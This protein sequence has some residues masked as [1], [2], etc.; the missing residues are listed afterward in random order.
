[1]CCQA[2]VS[3]IEHKIGAL[4]GVE[5]IKVNQMLRRIAVSH[6]AD[7][8]TAER[9][10]RTLNWSLLGASLVQK[11]S[12]TGL[13]RGQLCTKEAWV[14]LTCFVLF[15]IAGG[16]WARPES[17]PW[18]DDPFTYAALS[19]ISVGA[20]VLV[21]RTFAGLRYQRSLLNM[22]ATMLIAVVGACILRDFWEAA[23]IVFV[24]TRPA[25]S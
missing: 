2:E 6:D 20:P 12:T 8:V 7:K 15:A 25:S 24:R 22:F 5:G 13:R 11:G 16:I 3:L 18:H 9:L 21:M 23:A 10:L 19:C 1:M 14:A 17:T 4:N